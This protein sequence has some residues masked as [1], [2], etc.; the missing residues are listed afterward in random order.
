MGVAPY[1]LAVSPDGTKVYV[2]NF[3]PPAVSTGTVSVIKTANRGVVATIPVGNYPTGVAFTPDGTHAYVANVNSSI[4]SVIAT[5]TNTVVATV[6]VDSP[7]A[8]AITPDGTK[9]YVAKS[10]FPGNVRVI[11]TA[12]NAKGAAIPVGNYPSGLAIGP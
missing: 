11:A 5:A 2:T 7:V 3:G 8:V 10:L 9:V 6:T 12:T 4:V 1:G